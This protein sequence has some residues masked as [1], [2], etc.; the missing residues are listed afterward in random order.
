MDNRHSTQTERGLRPTAG[1]LTFI[2]TPLG[3]NNLAAPHMSTF[4]GKADMIF[5]GAHVCFK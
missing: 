5:C 2:T 3:L 4:G 1:P